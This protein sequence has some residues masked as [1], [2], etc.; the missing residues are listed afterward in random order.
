M[1]QT[2]ENAIRQH[3]SENAA[4]KMDENIETDRDTSETDENWQ[5]VSEPTIEQDTK[6]QYACTNDNHE[7]LWT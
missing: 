5:T 1:R 7:L 2:D 4:M 6:N 3:A